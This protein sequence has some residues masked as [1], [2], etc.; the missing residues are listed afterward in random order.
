[1][2]F[3][4]NSA[5]SYLLIIVSFSKL[6][7]I[8]RAKAARF[9]V[10]ISQSSFTNMTFV[11]VPKVP[12]NEIEK[13]KYIIAFYSWLNAYPLSQII[14]FGNQSEFA[15]NQEIIEYFDNKFRLTSAFPHIIQFLPQ[16]KTNSFGIPFV[17]DWFIKGM[18]YCRTDLITF[19]N[20]DIIITETWGFKINL[21]YKQIGNSAIIINGRTNLDVDDEKILNFSKHLISSEDFCVA[22]ELNHLLKNVKKHKNICDGIDIFTNLLQL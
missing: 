9:G 11:T 14:V 16:I 5:I 1:M 6:F 12:K 2:A 10:K 22:Q 15:F 17:N 19:I 3:Q 7:L 21:I 8:F 18:K 20:S 13:A 4:K